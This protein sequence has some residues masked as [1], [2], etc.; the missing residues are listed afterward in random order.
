MQRHRFLNAGVLA[1]LAA[2]LVIA[3]GCGSSSS[4]SSSSSAT[5]STPAAAAGSDPAIVAMLPSD[6]QK[7]GSL[8]VATDA[9]YAPNEFFEADG[10]TI[11]GMDI[12]LGH[13]I[14]EAAG[15]RVELRQ[16]QLRLDHPGAG[17]RQV[18]RRHVVLHR[19]ARSARRSSTSSPTSPPAPRSTSA[20]TAS[21]LDG[22]LDALCGRSVGVEKGTTQLDDAT[23]QSKKCT[24]AGKPAVERVGL[25]GPE[26]RQRGAGSRPRRRR[27]GR[28]ARWPSTPSSSRAASSC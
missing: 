10:T 9:S 23:A 14:G 7:G 6:L 21:R 1:A 4:D 27:D 12:D 2:T 8:T 13:A 19:H 25:P 3:A 24:D 18:R 5:T 11:T 28:L 15:R 16:R 20:R 26:R 17:V 22:G